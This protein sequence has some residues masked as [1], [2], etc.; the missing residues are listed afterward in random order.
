MTP[1]QLGPCSSF[2]PE[3]IDS[4]AFT[5]WWM[6]EMSRASGVTDRSPESDVESP[7]V[8]ASAASASLSFS[9]NSDDGAPT[10]QTELPFKLTGS[11]QKTAHALK[12]NIETMIADAG[13]GETREARMVD[14]LRFIGFLT[15]TVGNDS[16]DGFKQVWEVDEASR[17]INNLTRRVLPSLFT[18][19]VIVTERHKSGAIHFHIIGAMREDVR[20]GFNFEAFLSARQHRKFGGGYE[21]HERLYA[22]SASGALRSAWAMLRETL[23]GY[24]FGRSELT[25]I[26]KSGEAIAGYVSKYVSKNLAARRPEDKGKKLVRYS[27]WAKK[28]LTSNGFSWGTPRAVEWRKKAERIAALGGMV[29]E[30]VA[31]GLGP[32][33]AWRITKIMAAVAR[34]DDPTFMDDWR[35]VSQSDQAEWWLRVHLQS[36]EQIWMREHPEVWG[37]ILTEEEEA[38]LNDELAALADE[39]EMWRAWPEREAA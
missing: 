2:G 21:P 37:R 3:V 31:V 6:E 24:G 11:Q 36:V 17:R 28:H 29:R 8:A 26:R 13:R 1:S 38:A 18:R 34:E 14:G 20:T 30:D 15:L 33:W 9:H 35:D 27:G 25:P 39:C 22:E 32:R 5:A 10:A 16:D 4:G 23:P 19:S 12:V 7:D